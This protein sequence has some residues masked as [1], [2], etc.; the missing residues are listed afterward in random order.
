MEWHRVT[1]PLKKKLRSVLSAGKIMAT[2]ILNENGITLVNLLCGGT[3]VISDY[4]SQMLRKMSECSTVL[5]LSE[6]PPFSPH[7]KVACMRML[8]HTQVYSPLRPWQNL[9]VQCFCIQPI[10]LMLNLQIFRLFDPLKNWKLLCQGT[11]LCRRWGTVKSSMPEKGQQ[12]FMS[13]NTCACSKVE[14]DCWQ[15]WRL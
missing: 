10:V 8:V 4:Y 1:S 13:R 6:L 14:E 15:R 12:L 11:T 2:A 7:Q 9:D 5:S 3:A